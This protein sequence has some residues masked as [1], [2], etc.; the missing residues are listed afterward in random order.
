LLLKTVGMINE[1]KPDL[2]AMTG[3]FITSHAGRV[4][5][6]TAPLADLKARAGVVASLG[7]HDVWTSASK[8]TAALKQHGIR[9]LENAG[10]AL[11]ER[12]D[13]LWIAG[14]DSVWGGDPD[15][16]KALHGRPHGPCVML[17]HEPDY[18]DTL[19][20]APVNLLQLAGHTHGGQGCIPGGV[21]LLLPQW[22]K[23]YARGFFQVGRQSLY[24]NRGLGTLGPKA[25]FACSPEITEIT[26]TP[27]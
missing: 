20:S 3:D 19:A 15:L 8:V 7:N 24:V 10:F 9:V 2:I 17:A 16:G 11:T 5:E 23:K 1:L 21:P 13:S 22:G 4:A 27:A 14:L 25:R 6:L 18:I 12:S 26:L